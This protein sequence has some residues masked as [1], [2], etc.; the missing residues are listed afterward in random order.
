MA[1][2]VCFPCQG[3]LLLLVL[4]TQKLERDAVECRMAACPTTSLPKKGVEAGSVIFREQ[5]ARMRQ[6][7]EAVLLELI[8]ID[9]FLLERKA[10]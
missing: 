8:E 1:N 6:E 9:A 3:L 4:C 10:A 2:F 5:P 7:E